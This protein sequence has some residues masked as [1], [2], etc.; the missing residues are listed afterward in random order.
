MLRFLTAGE[1][2]GYGL[3][4]IIEG[5]PAGFT[6]DTDAIN[7][8]LKQRQNGYG[9][10]ARMEIE[11]DSAA[12]RSGLYNGKTTGAPLLLE[13]INKDYN[14]DQE[15]VLP[16]INFPRPGHADLAGIFKH[17]EKD[18]R[19]ISE[20]ASARETTIRTA[21]GN[22]AKQF[23]SLFGFS[24]LGFVAEIGGITAAIKEI[25]LTDELKKIVENSPLRSPDIS[26]TESMIKAIDSAKE[27]GDSLGGV[28]VLLISGLLPGLG[29]HVH[30]DRKLD[31]L[32]AQAILSIPSV[33]GVEIGLGFEG[34]K[35]PGSKVHDEIGYE[36]GSFIRYSNNAG[37]IEGGISNG[38]TIW[39]RGAV[40]PL[41]SLRTPLRSVDIQTKKA[42]L[43]HYQ[44]SDICVVPAVSVIAE[45][46]AAW[47]LAQA[48]MEKFGGDSITEIQERV[49]SYKEALAKL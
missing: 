17:G 43:A 36:N 6:I 4:S 32:L 3:Y 20:R 15:N 35:R 19:I 25:S 34:A 44:R 1:S 33:K 14:L 49:N 40:K 39:L 47:V 8:D 7:Q 11:Q 29:S 5:L 24:F 31:A 18:I 37:G 38:E 9:R 46:M 2:H 22:V 10:G 42:A 41:S 16:P 26:A 48:F 28:F 23:L 30:W 13:I 12:I 21:V 27:K 45:G